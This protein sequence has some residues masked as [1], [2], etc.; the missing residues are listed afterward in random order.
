[1]TFD[2]YFWDSSAE[3]YFTKFEL[4]VKVGDEWTTVKDLLAEIAGK[5]TINQ[6]TL[7]GLSGSVFR[8]YAEGGKNKG[9][10]ARVIID[11]FKAHIDFNE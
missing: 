1:M 4:Q 7:E 11:N 3:Q 2:C 8:F 10:D 5:T 9:N 6:I